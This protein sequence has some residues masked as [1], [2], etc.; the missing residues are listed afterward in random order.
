MQK[1]TPE[2]LMAEN[3][4]L[5]IQLE[6]AQETLDA[7]RRG[8]V[9]GLVVS[10]PK[11]EQVY[12]IS[13]AEK[14]YRILI[15]KMREGA[16]TLSD[17]NTV[18]YANNGFAR[19]LKY[20]L[21]KIVGINVESLIPP[22]QLKIFKDL[23]AECRS[24][25]AN[26][27][28]REI[29][30]KCSDGS[31]VPTQISVNSLD[32]DR[33]LTTFIVVTDLTQHM[34]EEIRRFTAQLEKAQV[35]LYSSEQRWA[36]TLSSIGDAVIATDMAGKVTF[37]NGVAQ[38]LT[39]WIHKEALGKAV[40]DVFHIVNEKTREAVETPIDRVIANS[41]IVGLAEHTVLIQKGGA[42]IPIDD[43][44]APIRDRNGNIVGVVLVFRDITERR[45]AEDIREKTQV[46]LEENAILLEEY[47]NQMEAL[48]NERAKQLQD[49][50][51]LAAIG[52]TAG[53]VG[54]DIRNPLQ[55]ISGDLYLTREELK[56]FPES[57]SKRSM[58]E[59]LGAIEENIYYINKIVSDLQDFTRPLKPA[60]ES[61]KVMD[62]IENVLTATR[63]PENINVD[64]AVKEGLMFCAD[65][66]FLRRALTN[67][68]VN[69][70]QAMPNGGQLTLEAQ[71]NDGTVTLK[72]KDTGVGI[73]EKIRRNLFTPLFTT[74]A[75][76]QGLGLAVVKRLIEAMNGS[77]TFESEPGKGTT[78][79]VTLPATDPKTANAE[80]T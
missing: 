1:K 3:E 27:L 18:L 44:G 17:D 56:S 36:T 71:S 34:D 38:E 20:P 47:A 46:K 54:H 77:I 76:G 65:V 79:K 25:N 12:S 9:D 37:M 55:A 14:P 13:G 78:F 30:F 24:G 26:S 21:E 58:D 35:A 2:D 72:V 68:V 29:S 5:R 74:K 52:Q 23:L 33:T 19:M 75:K 10:T 61:V 31:L 7:I 8:E 49:S 53:M 11:G 22:V 15:E 50:E 59:S 40:N 60:Y 67:L 32:M 16:I 48:A 62:Q 80:K 28:A 64:L 57:E 41:K 63:I 6:E 70:V 69:A 73:P 43:S 42:Q 66:A 4:Q 51:R 39:G 45:E